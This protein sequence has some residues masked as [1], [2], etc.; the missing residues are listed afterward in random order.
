MKESYQKNIN[1][2]SETE[3]VISI[4]DNSSNQSGEPI[5][6]DDSSD[7]SGEPIRLYT[8]PPAR[9]RV[10]FNERNFSLLCGI[11]AI[12]AFYSGA[13][14]ADP[15]LRGFCFYAGLLGLLPSSKL[16][17]DIFRRS[18]AQNRVPQN[19]ENSRQR[20]T[21][22]IENNIELTQEVSQTFETSPNL[23]NLLSFTLNGQR[24]FPGNRC[25]DISR[26]IESYPNL[27]LIDTKDL[28]EILNS[29][30]S[31]DVPSSNNLQNGNQSLTNAIENFRRDFRRSFRQVNTPNIPNASI[32]N[33]MIIQAISCAIIHDKL[34]DYKEFDQEN[35][36]LP[37]INLD[38]LREAC[39]K[40]NR[41]I[42]DSLPP[43]EQ[44]LFATVSLM[45]EDL[46]ENGSV[47]ASFYHLSS[48]GKKPET[49]S[50]EEVKSVKSEEEVKSVKS[51][52]EVKSG[53]EVKSEAIINKIGLTKAQSCENLFE[54]S[55]NRSSSVD[56]ATTSL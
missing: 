45:I 32:G 15:L 19:L 44:A 52:E 31:D 54:I 43:T 35:L 36:K 1:N 47:N 53:E 2:D 16:L 34:R 20:Q 46:L 8:R 24:N 4:P 14:V 42:T 25:N 48:L 9:N 13:T 12:P 26:I 37:N 17:Y 28:L 11:G 41:N 21:R 56:S 50:E 49:K 55:R 7:Q 40:L 39:R 5:R 22:D 29:I 51:E 18:F 6:F 30:F 10:F 38:E 23:L 27:Q 3:S 33:K